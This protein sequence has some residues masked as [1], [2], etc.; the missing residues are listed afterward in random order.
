M[1]TLWRVRMKIW[2]SNPSKGEAKV[3]ESEEK[4]YDEEEAKTLSL[5]RAATLYP[6]DDGWS[7]DPKNATAEEITMQEIED[8]IDQRRK[9]IAEQSD[10]NLDK[11]LED[12]RKIGVNLKDPR[13]R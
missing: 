12:L 1:K 9:E 2:N 4:A 5:V 3:F 10:E 6:I 7:Y 11:V 8:R 13:K